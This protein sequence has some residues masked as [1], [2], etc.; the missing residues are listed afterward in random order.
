MECSRQSTSVSTSVSSSFITDKQLTST[1]CLEHVVN[2][3][4]IDMMSHITRITAVE[5]ATAIWK[6]DPDL[7]DN[8]VLGGSLNVIAAVHTIAIRVSFL[9][10]GLHALTKTWLKI[11]ASGQ[12]IEYFEKIQINCKI[13]K[14]LQIPLHSNVWWGSA[15]NML[16][17][18][19]Q[20]HKVSQSFYCF[21]LHWFGQPINLFLKSANALYGPITTVRHNRQVVKKIPWSA[22]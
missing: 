3:A 4:N 11:Q 7:Y 12:Q 9:F 6:H 2:L 21:M 17:H 13:N 10:F 8:R 15:Y 22:F 14:P 5:N 16:K 1:S 20:L 18:A 19:L